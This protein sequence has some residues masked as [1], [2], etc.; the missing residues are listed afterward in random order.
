MWFYFGP[1]D[2]LF[3]DGYQNKSIFL[4]LGRGN[5]PGNFPKQQVVIEKQDNFN[6]NGS[7]IM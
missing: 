7:E 4:V 6:Y 1:C 5:L 3:Q 2:F